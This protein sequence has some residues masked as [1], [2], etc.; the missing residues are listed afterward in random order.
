MNTGKQNL[1]N[2]T[3]K[4]LDNEW[5]KAM[6]NLL[7]SSHIIIFTDI[8]LDIVYVN[9]LFLSSTEL[10]HNQILG[11]NLFDFMSEFNSTEVLDQWLK[12]L[13]ENKISE[14]EIKM[15]FHGQIHWVSFLGQPLIDNEYQ[16]TLGFIFAG[17]YTGEIKKIKSELISNNK[18]E[19]LEDLKIAKDYFISLLPTTENFKRVSFGNGILFYQPLRSI[20][21]DWYFFTLKN[22]KLFLLAGD[23]MGH[24]IQAGILTTSM[25]TILKKSNKWETFKDP[26]EVLDYFIKKFAFI[27]QLKNHLNVHLSIASIIYDYGSKTADYV[28]FNYPVYHYQKELNKLESY[29]VDIHV[30]S[31]NKSYYKHNHIHL[32]HGEWIWLFSD[33]AKDQY[34]DGLNKPLGIK[35]L[36]EILKET[37]QFQEVKEAEKYLALKRE[38]WMGTS[39]QTDDITLIGIKF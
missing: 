7:D 5:L 25:L 6:G 30:N 33:G 36:K 31:W 26:I 2:G 9:S 34:G 29:K 18:E 32:N 16:E 23:F 35:K 11:R 20:G 14:C 24:G 12:N 21:G 37:S 8:N 4:T 10:N 13:S 1:S 17:K 3:N 15:N 38:E 27:F 19:I 28:S 39:I 22:R